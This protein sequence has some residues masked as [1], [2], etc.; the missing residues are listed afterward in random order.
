MQLCVPATCV[1][2]LAAL[3]VCSGC[4]LVFGGGEAE[5]FA[6][7][8]WGERLTKCGDTYLA[9][10]VSP[11]FTPEFAITEYKDVS[12][13]VNPNQLSEADKLNGFEW[14]GGTGFRYTS[15]RF[16]PNVKSRMS[17]WIP[18]ASPPGPLMWKKKGEDWHVEPQKF[19]TLELHPDCGLLK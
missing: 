6:N 4:G 18:G 1:S 19:Y 13:W 16:R 9:H 17:D 7:K 10:N 2:V 11:S 12:V 15:M 5:R 3:L 8:Y 14:S